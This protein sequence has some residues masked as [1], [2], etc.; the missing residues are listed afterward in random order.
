MNGRRAI[1]LLVALAAILAAWMVIAMRGV[2]RVVQPQDAAV[3]PRPEGA[4]SVTTHIAS[5]AVDVAHESSGEGTGPVENQPLRPEEELV[6]HEPDPVLL[7]RYDDL[8]DLVP[9]EHLPTDVTWSC[10]RGPGSCEVTAILDDLAWLPSHQDALKQAAASTG[11]DS[12]NAY[13]LKAIQ[14]PELGVELTVRL[15]LP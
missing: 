8:L 2:P 6:E 12:P 3:V 15:D 13:M 9:E 10:T 14:V 7:A 5:P 1:L 4:E 11:V